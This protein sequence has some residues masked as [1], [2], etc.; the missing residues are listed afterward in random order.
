MRHYWYRYM[1]FS[2]QEDSQ[3]VLVYWIHIPSGGMPIHLHDSTFV[4]CDLSRAL[5]LPRRPA[6]S[7]FHKQ[8]PEQKGSFRVFGC[9]DLDFFTG[10]IS[11]LPNFG[12]SRWPRKEGSCDAQFPERLC[13]V[14][15]CSNKRGLAVI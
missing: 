10:D 8:L 11:C 9:K 15:P 5:P 3:L 6:A 14:N 7:I 1:N 13:I 12:S 2:K 4:A